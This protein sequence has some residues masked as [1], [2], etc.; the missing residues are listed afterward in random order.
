MSGWFPDP[1]GRFGRR[2]YDG[3]RWTENVVAADGRAVTDP[4][5]EDAPPYPPPPQGAPAP[6][7]TGPPGVSGYYGSRALASGPG[8]TPPS[9]KAYAPGVALVLGLVGLA[10]VAASLLGL[11]W[12]DGATFLDYGTAARK[13]S[14]DD[15]TTISWLDG[16]PWLYATSAGFVLL[17]LALVWV[18]LAG[19]P[20]PS[21]YAGDR[22]Q[23]IIAT[24]ICAVAAVLHMVTV[25]R[26]SRG[27]G[28]FDVGAWLGVVGYFVA[29][30]GLAVGNRRRHPSRVVQGRQALPHP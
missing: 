13:V 25:V 19:I 14:L 15:V 22:T 23:R 24:C 17:G 18:V 20:V 5:P 2:W 12:R 16:V 6:A 1:S 29:I 7:P 11:S 10:L 9:G 8:I 30:A 4:L 26:G 27:P 3:F 21:T 28:A